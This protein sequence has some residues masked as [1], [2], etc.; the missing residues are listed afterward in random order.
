[1]Q[2]ELAQLSSNSSHVIAHKSGHVV[3]RDE[4]DVIVA[5]IRQA[6]MNVRI[7]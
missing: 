6:A 7:P 2:L 5:A 1:M 4:P 3:N